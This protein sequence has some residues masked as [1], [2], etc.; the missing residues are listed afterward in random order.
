[1]RDLLDADAGAVD[2]A[3]ALCRELFAR[4]GY[5]RLETPLMEET[6]LFLRK[7]GGELS[8]RLYSFVEPGGYP[9]SLRPEYTAPALRHAIESGALSSL[10]LRYQY[11]GPVFRHSGAPADAAAAAATDAATARRQFT[12]TGAELIGASAPRADGEIISMAW[13]ALMELGVASPGVVIGHVGLIWELLRPYGLSERARLFLVNSVGTLRSGRQGA[14]TVRRQAA[15]L[16]FTTGDGRSGPRRVEQ[17]DDER[18]LALVESVLGETLGEPRLAG[19]GSRTAGEIVSRLARKLTS[20]DDPPRFNSALDLLAETAAVNGRVEDAISRGRRIAKRRA[21]DPSVFDRLSDVVSAA[22]DEGV[23][24]D[25]ITADLGLA[26]GI[27]YYTGM[28]FDLIRQRRTDGALLGGGGRYDG[29]LRALGA[30]GDAPALGFAFNLDAV[31]AALPARSSTPRN[32]VLVVPA[33]SGAHR[34]A[35]EHAAKLRERGEVAVLELDALG[36]AERLRQAR[37]SGARKVVSVTA[38]GRVSEEAV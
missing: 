34:A 28:V 5:V 11:S 26:R 3:A 35:S 17:L 33:T 15:E 25:A 23:P 37:S 1:M 9:V 12:Q 22:V 19:A 32:A 4:R 38:T 6:E 13:G 20:A 2:S 21:T 8:S 36:R 31:L 29:L 14:D 24:G 27:A 10:P 30:E 18:S 7:S 16:G